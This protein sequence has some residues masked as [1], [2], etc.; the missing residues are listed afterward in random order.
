MNLRMDL[1]LLAVLSAILAGF[2]AFPLAFAWM[3]GEN[4]W[5]LLLSLLVAVCLAFVGLARTRHAVPT[6]GPR[7]G[8]LVATLGWGLAILLGALPYLLSGHMYWIDAIFESTAGFTTTGSSILPHPEHLP[9]ALLLWRSMTQWIGGMGMLLLTIAIL[10]FLGVGGMQLMKAE[11]P[12]PN[13]ERLTPRLATTA[14]ILWGF[15]A[16]LTLLSCLLFMLSGMSPLDALNHAFTTMATGGFSTKSESFAAFPPM[17]QWWCIL[18]MV[19]SGTNFLI[20]YRLL[21]HQ[22]H[23]VFQ[24]PEWRLYLGTLFLVGLLMSGVLFHTQVSSFETA[25]RE[26]FFQ[27]VSIMTGTGYTNANWTL[28]PALLQLILLLLMLTGGMSGSTTGGIKVVRIAIFLKL[29]LSVKQRLLQPNRIVVPKLGS[30]NISQ[31]V[32]EGCVALA[33]AALCLILA[34]GVTLNLLG[35]DMGSALSAAVTCVANVGP[36]L[37]GTVGPAGDFASVPDIGKLLL[38]FDMVAGRLE[39]FTVLMLFSKRFWTT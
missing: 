35:M 8:F 15:Y 2:Q 6:L 30:R 23:N 11:V 7:D 31:E 29:F 20:H 19:L 32:A 12:G 33:V 25:L 21:V 18:F 13:K 24:D 17:A 16:G 26:G 5:P 3:H 37:M 1:R 10:P 28:W 9:Q 4:P 38:S 27:T 36:G 22:D 39:I 34:T 14:R